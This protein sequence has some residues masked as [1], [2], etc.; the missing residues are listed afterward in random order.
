[1]RDEKEHRENMLAWW[2]T[3]VS[4]EEPDEADFYLAEIAKELGV[5]LGALERFNE[6][7][8]AAFH[9]GLGAHDAAN[10]IRESIKE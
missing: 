2:R 1:M 3:F 8:W 10:L 7:L 4:D 6:T 9:D 5:S